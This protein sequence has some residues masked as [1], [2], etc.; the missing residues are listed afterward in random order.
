MKKTMGLLLVCMLLAMPLASAGVCYGCDDEDCEGE[1]GS[2]NPKTSIP[3][4]ICD[5]MPWYFDDICKTLL[6][7]YYYVLLGTEY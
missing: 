2:V 1:C 6:Q 5:A 4:E 3:W 7:E